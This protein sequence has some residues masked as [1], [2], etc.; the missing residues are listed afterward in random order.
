M[1]RITIA[2]IVEDAW[3]KKDYIPACGCECD[4]K[5]LDDV[6]AAFDALEVLITD[7]QRAVHI[8]STKSCVLLNRIVVQRRQS[9][10]P[11]IL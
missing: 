3:F 11:P 7:K 6:N 2:E 8:D 9:Q 4:A 1:Q 5:N 10:S